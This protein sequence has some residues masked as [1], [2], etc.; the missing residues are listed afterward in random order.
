MSCAV[1]YI[2]ETILHSEFVPPPWDHKESDTTEQLTQTHT[3]LDCPSPSLSTTSLPSVSVHL[4]L[5]QNYRILKTK[6]Q[7]SLRPE[8]LPQGTQEETNIQIKWLICFRTEA[9]IHTQVRTLFITARGEESHM[10]VEQSSDFLTTSNKYFLPC[11]EA[12]SRLLNEVR[13]SG[14]KARTR[15]FAHVVE[16][17]GK[18][19][20]RGHR[21]AV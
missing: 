12:S 11:S 21:R 19:S 4:L 6:F 18:S 14:W 13:C 9:Q 8:P 1:Q 5:L 15:N 16:H 2:P 20:C 7:K 3:P 10:A 17:T